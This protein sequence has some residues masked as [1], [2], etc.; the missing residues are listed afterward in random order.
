[1]IN[2]FSFS[3]SRFDSNK[4]QATT[5]RLLGIEEKLKELGLMF[6]P[7]KS[8]INLIKMSPSLDTCL[9]RCPHLPSDIEARR[10][11]RRSK[12]GPSRL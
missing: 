1:L 5:S 3:F 4:E 8:S 12:E 7:L 11:V 10:G 6:L 2:L 9:I